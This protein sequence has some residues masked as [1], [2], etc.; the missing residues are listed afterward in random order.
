MTFDFKNKN[1]IVIGGSRG[2]GSYAAKLFAQYGANVTIT[3]KNNLG[4]AE[5]TLAGL[6][7]G[8]HSF[9]QLDV[10]GATAIAAF[11]KL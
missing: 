4:A 8:N 1:V 2:I 9:F 10:S 7:P 3:Y 5:Q 6:E 11:Y